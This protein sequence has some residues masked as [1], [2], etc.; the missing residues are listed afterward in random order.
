MRKVN[1][2]IIYCLYLLSHYT[3]RFMSHYFIANIRMKDEKVYARYMEKIN[4]VFNRYK[5]EFLAG[6]DQ[7]VILE[8]K[9]NYTR[10]VLLRFPSKADFD[11]WYYSPE[12]QEILKYRLA[13]AECDTILI[14]DEE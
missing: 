11:D 10:T 14:A 7:P 8:G 3:N 2:T 12:Y 5:G 13:G 4:D 1:A 9:W 6:D